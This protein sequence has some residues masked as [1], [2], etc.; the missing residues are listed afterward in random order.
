MILKLENLRVR[1]WKVDIFIKNL[2]VKNRTVLLGRNG[3]GKSTLLATIIGIYKPDQGKI[4]VDGK[5]V[6]NLPSEK[7][8]LGY[9]PQAIVKIPMKP[10]KAM[11]Y[12]SKKFKDNYEEII[13]QLGIKSILNKEGLSAGEQQLMNIAIL[14]MKRPK[15]LLLDEPA[16]HLDWENKRVL[17]QV[18][19]K[20]DIPMLY[21]THD[22][23]EA[24]AIGQSLVML[25]KGII[26][27]PFEI[28]EFKKYENLIEELDMY[29]RIF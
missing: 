28:K 2:E 1:K 13:E 25:D 9:L 27:G 17:W 29:K 8:N 23:I 7:R 15:V 6:T 16:S 12:F 18:L 5:D 11:E 4:F 21:V 26:K 22:P 19:S 24:I 20:M 14:L 3:V 10:S